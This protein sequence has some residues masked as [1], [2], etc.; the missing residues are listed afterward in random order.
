MHVERLPA[1]RRAAGGALRAVR[2]SVQQARGAS[3]GAPD[4]HAQTASAP[5]RPALM[6]PSPAGSQ[7][8]RVQ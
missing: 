1:C 2:C 7:R 3:G 8:T 5:S 4:A 6:K